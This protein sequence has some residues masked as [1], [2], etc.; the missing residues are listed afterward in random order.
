MPTLSPDAFWTLLTETGLVDGD[1]SE[2]L[3][4]EFQIES[5][6]P[7]AT[8]EA[9]TEA[10]AKWLVRRKVITVWQARRLARGDRGPFFIGDYRLLE[11]LEKDAYQGGGRG[12]L[13]RARHEPSGRVLLLMLLDPERCRDLE[14]WTDIVRRTTAANR[15]ADPT[16]S[17]TWA[18]EQSGGQRFIVSEDV[19]GTT[20][21]PE[22]AARGPRPVAEVMALGL[23]IARAVAE[24]HRLGVVHGGISLE[25]LRREPPPAGGDIATG[26]VRLLQFPLVADPHVVPPRPLI[27]G[28]EAMRLLATRAAFVA[29]ELAVPGAACDLRSDVYAIGCAMQSL[30]TGS[31]PCWQGDAERTLAH[32]AFVGPEPLAPPRV[33]P[34][35][36][37]LVSYLVAR[38]PAARYQSAVEA[39]DAIAACLGQP[40]V[41]P[42][43]PAQQPFASPPPVAVAAADA[44]A[45]PASASSVPTGPRVTPHAGPAVR[46]RGRVRG[47]AY[48]LGAGGVVAAVVGVVFALS[49]QSSRKDARRDAPVRQAATRPAPAPEE[50]VADDMPAKAEPADTAAA[51]PKLVD[52][53]D[54]PW[55]SPT[56]GGPPTL[57]HL[58]PGS[59]L[60]LLARPADILC[61]EEGR[62]FVRALGSRVERGLAAVA[63]ACGCAAEEIAFIQAGWQADPDVAPDAVVGGYTAYGREPLPVA[64]DEGQRDAAWGSTRPREIDGETVHLGATLSYWLPS[65]GDGRVLVACPEKQLVELVAARGSTRDR[66]ATDWRERLEATLS[67]DLEDLVGMLDQTRHLTLF[68]SPSYLVHDGRPVLAGPLAKLVEPLA[69]LLGGESAA[70]AVSLHFAD[71]FYAEIDAIATKDRSARKEAADLAARIAGLAEVVEEYCNALDAHPYGRKLVMRLPRML[72]I[73]AANVRF[74]VEGK[75]IVVNCHL[76][77]HAGHNLALAAELALE[78]T[79]GAGGGAVLAAAAP[80]A[81]SAADRLARRISLVFARDTLEKS[82]QMLADETG[83]PME[84]LGKDLELEG[85]TKNQS[86]GLDEQD[87]P[88]ESILRTILAKSNPEGKLVYVVRSRDGVESL[89]ITTRAAAKKRGDELPAAFAAGASGTDEEKA[90]RP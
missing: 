88:A 53:P 66:A 85:I 65:D 18:L 70:A 17:R 45:K 41:S 63:A 83:V 15:A 46:G 55:A 47:L 4:S 72:G 23:A 43:L 19:A 50:V 14:V 86:F 87:K 42:T 89:D 80:S 71:T 81:E 11:R 31:L 69:A 52:S 35:V 37:T 36:A 39:A 54:A 30:L 5:L 20:L 90:T 40:P 10:I 61:S 32:A 8:P 28:P 38:D 56:G 77:M 1:R 57:A 73:L 12:H 6:S 7:A 34:E 67:P 9:V 29:P 21:T 78:Q 84:I 24:L 22:L 16:L 59:Q 27:E 26:R 79:P 60:V 58:P 49:G 13:F 62:L 3:R 82:V 48:L 76:P 68:G 33:P 25:A 75:G 74:G 51:Q 64:V 2:A 44:H